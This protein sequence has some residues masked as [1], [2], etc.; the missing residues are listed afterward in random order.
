MKKRFLFLILLFLSLHFSAQNDQLNIGDKAPEIISQTIKGEPFQLSSLNGKVV[1]L[2]FWASWC[3]PCIE[4]QPELAKLYLKYQDQVNR[5][6][7]EIVGFSL[8]NSKANWQKVVDRFQISWPQ[9]S[10]LKF[11]KSPVAKDYKVSE[12]PYNLILNTDGTLVAK[13]LHG[14][15]L[16]K[17]LEELFSSQPKFKSPTD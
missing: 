8:D 9:I 11:W 2:D 7:F 6:N 14:D 3:A 10:D 13:N 12:L 5:G 16:R 17:F 4:E 1:L 15:E